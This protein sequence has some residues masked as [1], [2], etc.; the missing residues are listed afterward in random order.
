[1]SG[2]CNPADCLSRG[3][4]PSELS[5]NILWWHGPPELRE[6]NLSVK[7]FSNKEISSIFE[8]K[9]DDAISCNVTDTEE[10]L[11][12]SK[13]SSLLKLQRV[14]CYVLRFINNCRVDKKTRMLSKALNVN[15]Y[16]QAMLAI[17]RSVQSTSF[18]DEIAWVKKNVTVKSNLRKLCPFVDSDQILRAGGRLENANIPFSQKHPIILPKDCNFTRLIVRHEHCALMHGGL[19]L[20]LSNLSLKYYIISATTIVKSVIN[21][22]VTCF[23]FRAQNSQQ[24]M[25]SL[26]QDRVVQDRV[27]NKIGIDYCGP[28]NIKQSSLRR[29][30]VSKGYVCLFV[31]FVTKCVHLELVSDL[32]SECFMAALKRFCS[33]RGLPH[34]I[35]CD[36]AST[37]RGANR[38]LNE[39]YTLCKSQAHQNAVIEYCSLKGIDFNF[40]PSYSP[41]WG[42]L[43]E[44]AVK[45]AKYHFKRIIGDLLFTYEQFNTIIIQVE[46]VLNSRPLTPIN[47]DCSDFSYLTPGHFLI[48]QSLTAVP[49]PEI[50][51]NNI[52]SLRFWKRCNKIQQHFWSVWHKSYLSQLL[53]RP[54]WLKA[55]PNIKEGVLVILIGLNVL[56][57]HWPVARVVRVFKG[58]DGYV[59]SVEVKTKTGSVHVRA[60][61][62]VAVLPIYD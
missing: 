7:P 8:C 12:L 38:Q 45:S 6:I 14:V 15:E 37:F 23:R 53:S 33:R 50:T 17:V 16:K 18:A 10:V 47:R 54:K 52:N 28:F 40:I 48:N 46:G 62:K 60:I 1:M 42:G 31:C 44:A 30:V 26:P 19:K 59:R 4:M 3:L 58:S 25:A 32:T 43:W 35:Y 36:N 21:K 9:N 51:T 27:F 5:S 56:P 55:S 11:P 20:T 13:F 34:T 29:S 41:T 49:E 57:L 61:N 24:L 22:C 39:L 2:S